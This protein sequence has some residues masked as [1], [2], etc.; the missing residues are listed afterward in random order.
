[1]IKKGG[2]HRL[3][4]GVVAAERKRDIAHSSAYLTMRQMCFNPSG[5]VNKRFRVRI[6]FLDT[7]GDRKYVRIE[8][9]IFRREANLIHQNPIRPG[10]DL[11]FAFE[12]VGLAFF[13]EGHNG[14]GGPLRGNPSPPGSELFF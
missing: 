3:A 6:V 9:D 7:G 1:M 5:S 11:S 13:V 10:A 12:R 14:N 2:M 4:H 8:N